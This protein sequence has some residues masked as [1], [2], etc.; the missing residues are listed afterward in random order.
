MQ[1]I[2]LAGALQ[3]MEDLKEVRLSFDDAYTEKD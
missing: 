1:G 2:E 3:K